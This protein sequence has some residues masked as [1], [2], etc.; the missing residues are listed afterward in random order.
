MSIQ[1]YERQLAKANLYAKVEKAEKQIANGAELIDADDV[2]ARLR[3]K[4]VK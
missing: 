4:Y 1:T 2:F 3:A